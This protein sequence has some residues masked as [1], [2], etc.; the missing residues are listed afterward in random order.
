M[1]RVSAILHDE[2]YLDTVFVND[3]ATVSGWFFSGTHECSAEVATIRGSVDASALPWQALRYRIVHQNTA[4]SFA[5]TAE[6][7]GRVPLSPQSPSLWERLL[8]HF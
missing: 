5:V 6:L 3:V 2:Y 7:G 1:E 8:A 4:Q